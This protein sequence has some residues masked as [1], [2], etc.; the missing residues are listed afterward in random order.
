M[1]LTGVEGVMRRCCEETLRV[2]GGSSGGQP[3]AVP[4]ERCGCACAFS[5]PRLQVV[6]WLVAWHCHYRL[7]LHAGWPSHRPTSCR[8]LPQPS[9]LPLS[10]A[11]PAPQVLRASKESILTVIE[12]F[13]HDPLYKWALTTTAAARRQTEAGA[14]EVGTAGPAGWQQSPG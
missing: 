1:G 9:L 4:T 13:I 2:S 6:G 10:P 11:L 8:L 12:V 14:E 7:P 3:T 5:W